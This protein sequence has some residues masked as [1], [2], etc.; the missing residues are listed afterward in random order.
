MASASWSTQ[1]ELPQWVRARDGQQA[2]NEVIK[3]YLK[4]VA[5]RHQTG[6]RSA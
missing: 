5:W 2:I 3:Q 6:I 4:Y 1:E